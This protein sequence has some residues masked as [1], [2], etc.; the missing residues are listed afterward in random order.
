MIE[1]K[2]YTFASLR[3]SL[4]EDPEFT[5]NLNKI[6]WDSDD[7]LKCHILEVLNRRRSIRSDNQ[8]SGTRSVILKPKTI[9]LAINETFVE[10]GKTIR[11]HHMDVIALIPPVS[12]G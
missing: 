12:G 8:V 11:L 2:I 4:L 3:S 9:M 10:P 7:E 5:L 1:V 6:D